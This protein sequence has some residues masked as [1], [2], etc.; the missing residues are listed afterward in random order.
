MDFLAKFVWDCKT[1]VVPLL[2]VLLATLVVFFCGYHAAA[3]N[4]SL[5]GTTAV[6]IGNLAW[7]TFFHSRRWWPNESW[8]KR[9]GRLLTF[10]R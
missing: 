3:E 6:V 7:V 2:A 8:P 4:L 5:F 1:V 10:D 9:L